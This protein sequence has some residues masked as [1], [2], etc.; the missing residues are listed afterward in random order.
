MVGRVTGSHELCNPVS[1]SQVSSNKLCS[2]VLAVG[3]EVIVMN[4]K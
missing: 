3:G 2:R 1:Q 4:S